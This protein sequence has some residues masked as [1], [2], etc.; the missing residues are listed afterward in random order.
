MNVSDAI[1]S[2]VQSRVVAGCSER[3][4]ETAL[5]RLTRFAKWLPDDPPLSD[6][7]PSLVESYFMHLRESGLAEGTLAGHKSS[8]RAFWSWLV[9]HQ[10]SD[11]DP[12]TILK[13]RRHS[14][15]FRPVRSRAAPADH[16]ITMVNSLDAYVAAASHRENRVRVTRI[17][18]AAL[19]SLAVDSSARRSELHNLRRGDVA[20][21]LAEPQYTKSGQVV[22]HA[23]STG[24]TGPMTVRWYFH[25]AQMLQ[26]WIDEQDAAALWLWTGYVG[27]ERLRVDYLVGALKRVCQFAGV[28]LIGWHAIRK[29]NVTDIIEATGDA[30]V[31]QLYANH[32]DI[33]TTQTYYN[34]LA[35]E[36]VDSAAADLA[37]HR[38]SIRSDLLDD[39]FRGTRD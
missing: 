6:V 28:P 32:A 26:R 14:Y 20:K 33:R 2:Y 15:S 23:P 9:D 21:A 7:T 16:F 10:Y 39:F 11:H 35:N 37:A 36:R 29:R 34:D 13:T 17:R 25:T 30:K 38:R 18:D 1:A 19:I 22:Y 3:T 4:V 31:G 5:H 12:S 27:K 24:K 8:Q